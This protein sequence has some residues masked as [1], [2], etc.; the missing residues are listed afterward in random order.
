[1]AETAGLQLSRRHF[2][3][4]AGAFWG[5]LA[6]GGLAS[7]AL[8]DT[9]SAQSGT[10]ADA[11]YFGGPIIN[12]LKDGDRAEALAVQNGKILA[13]GELAAVMAQKGP[14]TELVDLQGKTLMPGFFDP[15]SHVVLQ[16]AKFATAKPV[17][18][19]C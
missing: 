19:S 8:A 5:T 10:E 1:M 15:H 2:I 16:S 11:I 14:D 13:V 9:P 7:R 3:E 17:R 4:T 18:W 6:L 12:M